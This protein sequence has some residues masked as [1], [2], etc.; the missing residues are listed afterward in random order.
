[1]INSLKHNTFSLEIRLRGTPPPMVYGAMV[2]SLAAVA[3]L[4]IGPGLLAS[5]LPANKAATLMTNT[6]LVQAPIPPVETAPLYPY[7]EAS[8]HLD[9]DLHG[10]NPFDFAAA[11]VQVTLTLPGRKGIVRLPAFFDGDGV[12]RVRW[13]PRAPGQYRVS[14]VT[15]NGQP[16]KITAL[17]PTSGWTVEAKTGLPGGFVRRDPQ[18]F[19]RFITDDPA[20][21]A[22]YPVGH[23]VAWRSG[24]GPDVPAQFARM[25]TVGEN[26]SRVWMNHWDDKNLDWVSDSGAVNTPGGLHLEVAR[27]W[28]GIVNAAEANGIHFQMTL[29]HHG[30]YATR[31]N[32]NWNDNPWNKANGGFLASPEDFFT[33]AR[34]KALTKAKYRYIIARYGYSPAVMAWELFNEVQFTDAAQ[35]KHNDVIAAWHR[36]MADFVH[37]QDPYHHL[38]TTSSE[39][40][41]PGLFDAVDYLQAHTYPPDVVAAT[42][43]MHPREWKKPIFF[44]EIGGSGDLNADDGRVLHAI[45]WSSLMS[46]ASGAAQYWSWDAVENNYLYGQFAPVTAFLKATNLPALSSGM[47]TVVAT[48]QTTDRGAVSFGPGGGWGAAKA[49]TFA[50]SP[51]GAVAGAASMPAFLQGAAHAD[52]FAHA[53]FP[54]TTTAPATFTVTF[55]QV[56]KQ[57]AHPILRMD[58]QEVA[59]RDYPAS[60][61]DTSLRGGANASL[62]ATI[63]PGSHTIRLR[64]HRGRLGGDRTHYHC[65]VWTDPARACQ[66]GTD[67]GGFVGAAQCR[68][69]QRDS[70]KCRNHHP[71]RRKS[72]CG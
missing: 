65:P 34:A 14:T 21:S 44:G 49:T 28:D 55:R 16:A 41:M 42:Q 36:E 53:D 25:K 29:Q 45:L 63:P 1:M 50:V 58:G 18:D 32:P 7:L 27:K 17:S 30:Q 31:V 13:T 70:G 60:E 64:K 10:A 9:E 67:S 33:D 8:F 62:T 22:Y 68:D 20:R 3:G 46:E 51:E 11:D 54:L 59:A 57:G 24:N 52:L 61:N 43:S 69:G 6:G 71:S 39:L 2:V 23:N 5:L 37:A 35:A 72:S 38:V 47:H 4:V 26:W 56:A 12:W 40:T 19:A 66:S 15:L 48:A